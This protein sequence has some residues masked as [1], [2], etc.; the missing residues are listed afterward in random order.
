MYNAFILFLFNLFTA[1]SPYFVEPLVSSVLD[2][3]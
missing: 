1:T 3:V 2:F